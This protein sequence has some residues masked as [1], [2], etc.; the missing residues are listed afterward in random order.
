ME[1]YHYWTNPTRKT[2]NSNPSGNWN[3]PEWSMGSFHK[4][5]ETVIE[6]EEGI[7]LRLKQTRTVEL[8]V[9]LDSRHNYW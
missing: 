1:K 4:T 6:D 9:S 5:G 2:N 7:K 3:I 8:Q